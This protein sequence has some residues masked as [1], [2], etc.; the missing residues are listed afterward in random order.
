MKRELRAL[1]S[2]VRGFFR[3]YETP[4]VFTSFKCYYVEISES[5]W[6]ENFDPRFHLCHILANRKLR[7]WAI[8]RT[9]LVLLCEISNS[10]R[11]NDKGVQTK[12]N[13]G[14]TDERTEAGERRDARKDEQCTWENVNLD[15]LCNDHVT[16]CLGKDDIIIGL[17]NLLSRCQWE[18]QSWRAVM[19]GFCL[20]FSNERYS[21]IAV[22][23]SKQAAI[24]PRWNGLRNWNF[25]LH[26]SKDCFEAIFRGMCNLY[27][28]SS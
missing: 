24:T 27:A 15:F 4:T 10:R 20:Y 13:Y 23:V 14:R 22:D 8:V 19:S 18:I 17:G 3:A 12:R 25:D 6:I 11:N 16:I 7:Y 26:D 5:I 9:R 1:I 21:F 2:R 28:F